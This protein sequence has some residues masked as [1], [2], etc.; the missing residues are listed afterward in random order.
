PRCRRATATPCPNPTMAGRAGPAAAK[1]WA[2]CAPWPSTT[3]WLRYRPRPRSLTA[4]RPILDR[5]A[6]NR[7]KNSQKLHPVDKPYVQDRQAVRPQDLETLM[8]A[9]P[10]ELNFAQHIAELN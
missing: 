8:H 3:A 1:N 9:C 6:G 5:R 10:A 7:R 2:V 4:L